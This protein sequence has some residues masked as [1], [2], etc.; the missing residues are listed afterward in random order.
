MK[1][2]Q[3]HRQDQGL[4]YTS[5]QFPNPLHDGT[6]NTFDGFEIQLVGV[7][8]D[9]MGGVIEEPIFS[10][11]DTTPLRQYWTVYGHALSGGA[12]ALIDV[13]TAEDGFS[14]LSKLGVVGWDEWL[15]FVDSGRL[16]LFGIRKR[17]I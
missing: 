1:P 11:M 3:A 17:R 8:E 5:Y 15:S 13:D 14:V 10:F 12:H 4:E 9:G 6:P 2:D 7:F 16:A